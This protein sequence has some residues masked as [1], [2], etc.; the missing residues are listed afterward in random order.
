MCFELNWGVSSLWKSASEK[1]SGLFNTSYGNWTL[2]WILN[3]LLYALNLGSDLTTH[4]R[5]VYYTTLASF[6]PLHCRGFRVFSRQYCGHPWAPSFKKKMFFSLRS[7][8]S[9]DLKWFCTFK[10]WWLYPIYLF[11]FQ[12]R[13]WN[14]KSDA[15]VGKVTDRPR[16][17]HPG[18][19][20]FRI[21]AG[22]WG[23]YNDFQSAFVLF[24]FV[25]KKKLT[26]WYT[27]SF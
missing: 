17:E 14:G 26:R 10:M 22:K 25:K 3:V 19:S 27:V 5:Y 4:W 15:G 20:A 8:Y 1:G 9:M 6:P 16:C 23:I 13:Y 24:I 2:S 12:T 7:S 18:C 21:P 11:L